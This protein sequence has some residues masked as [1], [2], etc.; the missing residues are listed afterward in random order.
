MY[1]T[2]TT[3]EDIIQLALPRETA[4]LFGK[5]LLG[6]P[7][8]WAASLRPSPPAF[9]KLEGNELALVHMDDLRTLDP[10]MRLDR[11]VTTLRQARVAAIAV[12]G[13]I[14]DRAVRAAQTC[15][16]PL[17]QLPA[18]TVI[19]QVE[20][21]VIRL[22]VDREGYIAQRTSELQ[23]EL[24]QIELHGG[25]LP[26]IARL[27][28]RY[29]QQATV[30]LGDNGQVIAAAGLHDVPEQTVPRILASLP[31]LTALR[32]LI[33]SQP[34]STLED[35]IGVLEFPK[36]AE[37]LGVSA[38][39]VSAFQ[40]GG[41]VRGY[42]L[43]L[44][45]CEHRSQDQ[46]SA[47]ES[48]VVRQGAAAAALDWT[49]QNAVGL[50][51][52]QMR[53]AFLDELLASEVADEAA[54]IKRGE[55]LGFALDA[56]HA[57]WVIEI[58][59]VPDWPT[60]LLQFVEEQ[61]LTLPISQRNEGTVIFW[62]S[63]SA[64]SARSQKL[65]AVAFAERMLASTPH[66][67]IHI[68]IGRPAAGPSEWLRS[69]QQA[70]ESW[71]IGKTWQASPVTYFGDLGLYKLLTSL[72]GSSEAARFF[73]KTVQPIVDHDENRNSE[74]VSTLEAF[75][76]CHGNLSQT[77]AKLHIHRNTLAYRI[78]Q[79]STITRL[80]LNDPDARFALQLALKLRPVLR[81]S[82]RF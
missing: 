12:I 68:G 10:H 5:G 41:R 16:L 46:P 36:R 32:S 63:E 21:S 59:N 33:A 26:E 66:A 14:D 23:R 61:R 81:N 3:L 2:L 54:W 47:I 53:A 71:R 29:S 8:S 69:L 75:F 64:K 34:A 72:G 27:L 20:R 56:P 6:R 38:A 78:D 80:D 49:R 1:N 82:P 43:V 65:T 48:L 70:R 76:S 44:R 9:P 74:L 40:A 30:F 11:V 45:D 60:P 39:V 62:P 7:V 58:Q 57:A 25:G 55:T 13:E 37:E 77:A 22:I 67:H 17:L 18:D 50:A 42:C 24:T 15:E 73:R 35:S 79:I 31:S 4:L 19:T 51:Q 28:S 52:D